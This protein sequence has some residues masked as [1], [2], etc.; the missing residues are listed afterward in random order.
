METG[1]PQG[2]ER[3]HV[4]NGDIQRL[5]RR[6]VTDAAAQLA[7]LLEGDEGA[8]L[9]GQRIEPAGN[10]RIACDRARRIHGLAGDLEQLVFLARS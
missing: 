5:E 6:H 10:I 8:A 7:V 9:L 1:V 2:S 4:A 3:G